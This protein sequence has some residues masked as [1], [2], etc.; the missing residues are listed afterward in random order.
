MSVEQKTQNNQN[1]AFP[2]ESLKQQSCE[3]K[4]YP[5]IINWKESVEQIVN[6]VDFGKMTFCSTKMSLVQLGICLTD[7][8]PIFKNLLPRENSVRVHP[9]IFSSDEYKKGE[10]DK[11]ETEQKRFKEIAN[12]MNIPLG[13]GEKSG[14]SRGNW[15]YEISRDGDRDKIIR[16]VKDPSKRAGFA[17][18]FMNVCVIIRVV[19]SDRLIN[20]PR[21]RQVAT[22]KWF[23]RKISPSVLAWKITCTWVLA[24]DSLHSEKVVYTCTRMKIVISGLLAGFQAKTRANFV[25]LDWAPDAYVAFLENFGSWAKLCPWLHRALAH[26]PQLVELN[27]CR[28]LKNLSEEGN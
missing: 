22:G 3:Q 2:T 9:T 20:V 19:N 13:R 8:S 1:W 5:Q 21:L 15:F 26:G 14:Q 4:V 16:L 11:F 6:W 25:L 27:E 24:W 28:G 17:R 7:M 23:N 18:F 10:K 12:E